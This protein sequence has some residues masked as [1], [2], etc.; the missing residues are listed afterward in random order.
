[1]RTLL[2]VLL[3]SVSP[4]LPAWAESI[5]PNIVF[6]LVDDMGWTGT[7]L[8][9]DEHNE[10]SKSDFYLTP[11]LEKLAALGIRFSQAYSP[12]SMCTP[13]RA[14]LLTGKSPAQLHM[15]TPGNTRS[16]PTKQKVLSPNHVFSFPEKEVTIAELLKEKGYATAH[17]G[18]WHLSGDGPGR[19]GFDEHDGNTGNVPPNA[20]AENPK[21]IFGV[22]KRSL[23]FITDQVKKKTPFYVQL[24]HYAIH[25]PVQAL[26]ETKTRFAN[27]PQGRV[28]NSIDY[29]AMTAD[30]D[31]SVG[32]VLATI[33]SLG[34]EK[35]TW[36]IFMSDNGAGTRFN[37]RENWPLS[38]GKAS[39]HEG[40]IRVPLI[41]RG[42]SVSANKCSRELVMGVDIFNTICELC[43]IKNLPRG[44]EGTSLLSHIKGK[45]IDIVRSTQG[46]VFHFPHYGRGPNQV[47]QSAIILGNH[48][49][50]KSYE[51]GKTQLF[52]LSR[53]LGESSDL[54]AQMP[55]KAKELTATLDRYLNQVKAQLPTINPNYDAATAKQERSDSRRRR[56]R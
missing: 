44:V 8:Y 52:D 31:T 9:M 1:M 43:G 35:N 5:Q 49:L 42:P 29:A 41:I 24:S 20:T 34:I 21:D 28:H 45:S 39:L 46:H 38:H 7:S 33:K 36:V 54:S 40:G 56:G 48:K 19:H 50:I 37:R 22:T 15:T 26:E 53:D 23:A 16:Q 55:G 47:P 6:I 12:S 51:S 13:S 27:R 2:A 32:Q 10:K 25:E 4:I 30:F 14:S 3:V 17:F 11:N 18:K